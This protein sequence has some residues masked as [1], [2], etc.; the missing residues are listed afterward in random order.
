MNKKYGLASAGEGIR[1]S[2]ATIFAFA[3]LATIG[4][5]YLIDS[6]V[7]QKQP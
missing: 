5:C 7:S 4:A 2:G 3:A 1:I 6:F